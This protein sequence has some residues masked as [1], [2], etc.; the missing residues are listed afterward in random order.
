MF[1]DRSTGYFDGFEPLAAGTIAA[2]ADEVRRLLDT[3][4]YRTAGLRPT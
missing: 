1:P 3:D 2:V 4:K